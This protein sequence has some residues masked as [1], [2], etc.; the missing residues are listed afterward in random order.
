MEYDVFISYSRKDYLDEHKQPI[1][2]NIISQIKELFDANN[3]TYWLDEQELSG[4]EFTSL[5]TKKIKASRLFLFV[6]SK[7][8]NVSYYTSNEI[9]VANHYKKTIIPFRYDDSTYDDSVMMLIAKLDYIEYYSNPQKGL[10]RLLKS[11]KGYIQAEIAQKEK[12]RLEVE[13]LQNEIKLKQELAEKRSEI[14]AQIE[15]LELRKADVEKEYVS[16]EKAMV[17]LRNEK[18]DIEGRLKSLRATKDRIL[19]TYEYPHFS[20][21]PVGWKQKFH[22]NERNW[23]VN[24][25]Y[26]AVFVLNAPFLSSATLFSVLIAWS[27][28]SDVEGI[29]VHAMMVVTIILSFI[30]YKFLVNSRDCIVWLAVYSLHII[31]YSIG[32][33]II[34]SSEEIAIGVMA[35]GVFIVTL[36]TSIAFIRKNKKSAWSLLKKNEK[37]FMRDKLQ[38]GV[39]AFIVIYYIVMMIV[40]LTV[41][42]T[43]DCATN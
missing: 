36:L 15:A 27:D 8:S 13:R 9:A 40:Y 35:G 34:G 11:V 5:I 25:V 2:G 22:L 21:E 7:N 20:N 31:A 19:G 38:M 41:G 37:G 17:E 14:D 6:S 4:S 23:F 24:F 42:S 30:S 3:I 12:E 39:L 32:A 26:L 33:I 10:N 1:P 18:R 16:H 29:Y 43:P 28:M